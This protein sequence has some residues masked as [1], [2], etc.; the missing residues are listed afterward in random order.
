MAKLKLGEFE[1]LPLNDLIETAVQG[2]S[3]DRQSAYGSSPS[4]SEELLS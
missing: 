3:R 1:V 2:R 4:S